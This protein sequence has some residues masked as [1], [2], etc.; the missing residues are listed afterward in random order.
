MRSFSQRPVRGAGIDADSTHAVGC[1]ELHASAVGIDVLRKAM[2]D[3]HV[4]IG[5][6]ARVKWRF[7][8]NECGHGPQ[9]R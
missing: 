6:C 1:C 7:H 5:R 8:L 9:S 2:G 4:P 3:S